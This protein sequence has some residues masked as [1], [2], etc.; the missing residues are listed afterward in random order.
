[1]RSSSSSPRGLLALA[2][3][4]ALATAASVSPVAALRTLTVSG[5]PAGPSV[6]VSS[7]YPLTI[8]AS[9]SGAQDLVI[10]ATCA[11]SGTTTPG[12]TATLT[13]GSTT[14]TLTLTFSAY[15]DTDV[16]CSYELSGDGAAGDFADVS[17]ASQ[18]AVDLNY[19]TLTTSASATSIV[20]GGWFYITVTISDAP[21]TDKVVAFKV[22]CS[23]NYGYTP[24]NVYSFAA[25]GALSK[26]NKIL[27]NIGAAQSGKTCTFAKDA[28]NTDPRYN[29]AIGYSIVYNIIDIP[30]GG[31]GCVLEGMPIGTAYTDVL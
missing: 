6:L 16:V 1:M 23:G 29:S 8:T 5:F 26:T 18:S 30:A 14:T 27:L 24:T 13:A 2:A 11:S 31:P 7:V 12:G 9:Q 22:S 17:I 28:S 25:G 3:L 21:L 19:P 15:Y 10:T 4:L 20:S